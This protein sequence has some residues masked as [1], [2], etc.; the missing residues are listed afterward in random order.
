MFSKS[1]I[2]Y[3]LIHVSGLPVMCWIGSLLGYIPTDRLLP[4]SLFW[5]GM[6]GV[7]LL[8]G[9]LWEY[10]IYKKKMIGRKRNPIRGIHV[11]TWMKK[12]KTTKD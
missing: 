8:V 2:L 6:M 11:Y 10:Y 12:S 3:I 1:E 7:P 5:I 9:G 4:V